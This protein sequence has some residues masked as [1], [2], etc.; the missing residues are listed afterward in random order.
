MISFRTRR[1][2]PL[3]VF[4]VVAAA[5]I[6]WG[7]PATKKPEYA[8]A[9]YHSWK[10]TTEVILD[11]PIPG[12]QDRFRIPRMN[13]RGFTVRPAKVSGKL[14]WQFPVGTVI[15][16]EV[17]RTPKPAPGESPIQL[18]IMVKAPGDPHAQGGWIWLTRDLPGGQETYFMGNFCITCH[19]NAN[20]KHP[21][22]DGN[23]N[24][25]FRDYVYF[26]P[27]ETAGGSPRTY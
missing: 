25:E 8:A 19:A 24:E 16:K 27:K 4:A 10:R 18:T 1:I 21:Y 6:L 13:D 22:G 26:V 3:K 7:C 11:Y 12:H 23:P 14:L 15:V 20:E 9:D 17:Y 5:G 2:G